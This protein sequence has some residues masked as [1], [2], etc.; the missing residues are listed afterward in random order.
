M[1]GAIPRLLFYEKNMMI[2]ARQLMTQP[3]VT[4]ASTDSIQ[5]AIELMLRHRISGLPVT[6]P[7]P[8][9]ALTGMLTEGD[10][11]RRAEI[12]TEPVHAHWLAFFMGPG[13][14]AEEYTH[15]HSQIVAD[16]MTKRLIHAEPTADLRSLVALMQTNHIKRIPILENERL[17]GV[18]GRADLLRAISRVY[19][20]AYGKTCSDSEIRSRLWS[21]LT[22]TG[23]A[24]CGMITIDV[25][26]GVVTLGGVIPDGRD[27]QALCAAAANTPGV[28]HVR[29]RMTWVDLA[30]GYVIDERGQ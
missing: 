1:V 13:K 23:W 11:L 25:S 28:V 7:G 18:V 5:H 15:A 21:E 19:A 14:L 9:G 20:A 17:I 27:R 12:G 24:P 22:A 10:L 30:T 3:V 6:G 29:D 2:D 16:V 8:D 26:A 4:V